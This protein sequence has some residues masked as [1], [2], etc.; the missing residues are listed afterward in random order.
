MAWREADSKQAI[1]NVILLMNS[2][3]Q[4]TETPGDQPGVFVC[5]WQTLSVLLVLVIMTGGCSLHLT[6]KPV[7]SQPTFKTSV[8]LLPVRADRVVIEKSRR[9]LSVYRQG[10]LL[11]SFKVALGRSPVGPKTCQGDNKTP[12]GVY[13]VTEHKRDSDFYHALRLSYPSSEDITRAK[14]Q[15]CTPGGDIMIHGLENGYGWVGT[16]HQSADWTRGCIAVTNEEMDRLWT[17]VL[18]NTVVE[19]RP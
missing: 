10:H 18:D 2:K 5:G 15:G 12:E 11:G 14:A 13:T 1:E 3:L 19:I 4:E 6:R 17:W 9:L 16:A 7:S 8:P